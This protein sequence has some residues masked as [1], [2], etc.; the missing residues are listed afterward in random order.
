MRPVY[1]FMV[2][3]F[4][5]IVRLARSE[6]AKD[7]EILALRHEVSFLRRQVTRQRPIWADRAVLAA[8]ARL[9]S[10][11]LGAAPIGGYGREES[12]ER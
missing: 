4:G 9:L 8:L 5:W 11:R 1:L 2:R 10:G 6:A 12:D 7:A 3:I